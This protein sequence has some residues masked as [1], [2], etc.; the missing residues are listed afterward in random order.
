MNVKIIRSD[1][2]IK[3]HTISSDDVIKYGMEKACILGNIDRC[4][5]LK[6]LEYHT[7]FPYIEIKRFYS[8][9]N[10]MLKEG[11]LKDDEG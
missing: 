7:V 5:D 10:E 4:S 1:E 9:L 2:Y 8:L 3:Y 6:R 11:I